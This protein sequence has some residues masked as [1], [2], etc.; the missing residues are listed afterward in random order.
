VKSH[1]DCRLCRSP[2]EHVDATPC[3]KCG[4]DPHRI[5][6]LKQDIAESFLHDSQEYYL[7]EFPGGIEIKLCDSCASDCERDTPDFW[8]R[9]LRDEDLKE[10]KVISDEG[11]RATYWCRSCACSLDFAEAVLK[12]R[13]ATKD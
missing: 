10:I 12:V 13:A 9:A 3:G 5:G 1:L 6:V 11:I 8:G 4:P 7:Y 2:L